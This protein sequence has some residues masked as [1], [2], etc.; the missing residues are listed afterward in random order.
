MPTQTF[1]F[2]TGQ[3]ITSSIKGES[4]LGGVGRRSGTCILAVFRAVFQGYARTQCNPLRQPDGLSKESGSTRL[5]RFGFIPNMHT[6]DYSQQTANP[7]HWVSSVGVY[8]YYAK[9]AMCLIND[10]STDLK[11][12]ARH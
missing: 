2:G 11:C 3:Q 1:E 4:R 8:A 9:K 7:I 5:I 10:Q 12:A 6:H